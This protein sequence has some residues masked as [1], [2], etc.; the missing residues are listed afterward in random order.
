MAVLV[1][2]LSVSSSTN[3]SFSL[4]RIERFLAVLSLLKI[5]EKRKTFRRRLSP[6]LRTRLDIKQQ[7]C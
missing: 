1:A 3:K 6:L 5:V 2:F 7:Q 4:N